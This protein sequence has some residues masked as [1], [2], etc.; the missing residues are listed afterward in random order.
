MRS[1]RIS[2]CG[3]LWVWL[4]LF[5]SRSVKIDK[6]IADTKSLTKTIVARIQEHQVRGAPCQPLG[7]SP[8]ARL[9][10]PGI[11]CLPRDHPPFGAP[12]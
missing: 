4:P 11:P 10:F 1:P 6:V 7:R 8:L 2:V 3:F 5:Y 9:G 12:C